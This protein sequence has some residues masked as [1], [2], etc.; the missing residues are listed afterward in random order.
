LIDTIILCGGKGTRLRSVISDNPKILADINGLPFIE[1]LLNY[2]EKEGIKRAILCTG[3]KHDQIEDWVK[4]SYNGNI[5]II[6]SQEKTPLGTAGAIKIAKHLIKSN[7]LFVINGDTFL[8][9]N[10]RKFLQFYYKKKAN[11]IIALTNCRGKNL[12]GQI[13]IDEENRIV[14]FSEK[15]RSNF[16][17][18]KFINAGVYI[19]NKELLNFI[20]K[21]NNVSFEYYLLPLLLKKFERKIFGYFCNGSFIDIGTPENLKK[22]QHILKSIEL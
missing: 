12:Y 1:Y 18:T 8:E 10:Y 3:Y 20:P 11:L 4:S 15:D 7:N 9:L 16:V 5:E 6:L 13:N 14:F 21:N 22:S 17:K 19:L 2:L